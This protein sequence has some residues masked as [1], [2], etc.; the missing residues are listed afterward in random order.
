MDDLLCS[1]SLFATAGVDVVVSIMICGPVPA[2]RG[3]GSSLNGSTTK[4]II[5]LK[6]ILIG[7]ID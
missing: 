3:C 2:A 4:N 7:V 5:Q 6:N 1:E